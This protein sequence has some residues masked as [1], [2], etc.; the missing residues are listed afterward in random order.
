MTY[1]ST[2][3]VPVSQTKNDIE[4]LVT[5]YECE[6]FGIMTDKKGAQVAFQMQSRNILF[7]IT[8]PEHPQEARARWRALLLVVKAKME[9]V[10]AGIEEFEEAFLAN[11]VMPGGQTVSEMARP[12]IENH[13]NGVG[14]NI[15]LLPGY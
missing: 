12:I 14:E 2:T 3:K 7:K 4:K 5:K 11:I 6:A 1:A 13:Y 10:D 8:V 15:P 9:S